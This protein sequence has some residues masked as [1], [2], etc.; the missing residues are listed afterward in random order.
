MKDTGL[1]GQVCKYLSNS[2]S[3]SKNMDLKR[4]WCIIIDKQ[5]CEMRIHKLV[6]L[7]AENNADD[8]T[9]LDLIL[10]RVTIKL[11]ACLY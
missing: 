9:A 3:V 2:A 4:Y 7:L 1:R 10:A 8:M 5:V 11:S 6:D